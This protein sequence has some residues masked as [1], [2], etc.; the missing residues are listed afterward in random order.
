MKILVINSGSSSLKYSV[1]ETPRE[2]R[3]ISG[4][5]D[6]LGMENPTHEIKIGGDRE[7]AQGIEASNH[8][9]AL[10][11]VLKT[12][13][14]KVVSDL[15]EIDAVAHRVAHGGKFRAATIITDEVIAEARRM[16]PMIPLHHPPMIKEIE[17][18]LSRM[19]HSKHVA[20]FDTWFHSTIPDE[21]AIYGLPYSYF[22]DRGYKKTGFHGNS[23]A[24]VS[25]R[26]AEFLGIPIEELRIITCHL[27]NGASLCAIDKGRSIDTTLGV[28]AVPGVIM[29]TR[30]GDVDPGLLPVIMKEDSLSP[31]EMIDI[32]YRKSGLK[33][34]SGISRDMRDIEAEAA[35][36]NARAQLAFDAFCYSVKRYIGQ[37][38][39]ALG[40]CDCLVFCG[41]I[42]TNSPMVR[43]SSLKNTQGLGFEL[44]RIKN[45]TA[46]PDNS[47]EVV[48]I[49]SDQSKVTILAIETFEEI[50]MARQCLEALKSS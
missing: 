37:M 13:A 30:T 18:C 35:K 2:D 15:G 12:I 20:V 46:G 24:Y 26:A 43:E 7:S 14:T 10:D 9:E 25:R 33:G 40:G 17:E 21:A 3:L 34:I 44:D 29:G 1:F 42:G 19:P 48:K 32:L 6:R 31:D 28:T 49:S 45:E 39:I 4:V 50:M 47:E 38:L 8:G 11:E 36:G 27:G 23:H 41:G 16:T 22:H 5:I